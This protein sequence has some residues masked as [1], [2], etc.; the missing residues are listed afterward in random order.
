MTHFLPIY[1]HS[2]DLVLLCFKMGDDDSIRWLDRIL[3]RQVVPIKFPQ[4]I[5]V[6]TQC[7][8]ADLSNA[9]RADTLRVARERLHLQQDVYVTSSL[10]GTGVNDLVEAIYDYLE[11]PEKDRSTG[12]LPALT[13]DDYVL[14]KGSSPSPLSSCGCAIS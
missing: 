1:V 12:D 7:D 4:F 14:K 5:V 6:A 10:D 8:R 13:A 3:N 9:T 11:A 2:S